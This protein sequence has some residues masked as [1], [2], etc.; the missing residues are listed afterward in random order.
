MHQLNEP[1]QEV[2]EQH[3]FRCRN[4]HVHIGADGAYRFPSVT[5]GLPP[6]YLLTWLQRNPV[7]SSRFQDTVS[8]HYNPV[9]DSRCGRPGWPLA[10]GNWV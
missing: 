3:I 4:L 8:G 10:V 2:N 6:T 1:K 9:A 7:Y 5:K